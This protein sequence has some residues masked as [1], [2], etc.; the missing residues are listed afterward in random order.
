MI[1]NRTS[2]RSTAVSTIIKEFKQKTARPSCEKVE[3]RIAN[4]LND[5]IDG[6]KLAYDE[7]LQKGYIQENRRG[8]IIEES[9][10]D[11]EHTATINSFIDG[12]IAGTITVN[13]QTNLPF[14]N[15]WPNTNTPFKRTK[16]EFPAEFTRLAIKRKYRYNQELLKQLFNAAF[17]YTKYIRKCSEIFIEVTPSHATFYRDQ[18]CFAIIGSSD[19]C[20]RVQNTDAS[21]L[22][23]D[24]E[25]ENHIEDQSKFYL[26][27]KSREILADQM[28]KDL[29]AQKDLHK[30]QYLLD[31]QEAI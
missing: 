1:T 23:L 6:Y 7:Y 10:L 30:I 16:K 12:A 3:T 13:S 17:I 2:R 29:S 11:T 31:L 19:Y 24:V 9:D 15:T 26:D 18:M 22:W 20:T 21:L 25:W 27:Q 14:Q 5:R 4:N 8:M 28:L